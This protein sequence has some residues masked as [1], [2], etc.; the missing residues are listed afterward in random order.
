MFK[1]NKRLGT[2]D[3]LIGQGTHIDGKLTS[4]AGIRIEGEYHGEIACK[5]DVIIG[6]C[7]VVKSN[8]TAR[9]VIV[10]GKVFGDIH[11]KGRLTI[12]ASGHLNGNVAAQSL[13]IQEGGI[14]NGSSRMEHTPEAKSRPLTDHEL[15]QQQQN[16][17]ANNKE[18]EKSRQAG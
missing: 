8:I 4:E 11:T 6:E 18:K 3:T 16:K 10:A 12:T 1:E 5:G 2:T 9:D 15:A 13:L 14:F 7:G 17:E